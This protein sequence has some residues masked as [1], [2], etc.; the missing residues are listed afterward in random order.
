ML[1]GFLTALMGNTQ[2]MG[3]FIDKEERSAATIQAI[4]VVSNYIV[5]SQ[6]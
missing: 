2:L 3:Y 4:G 6:V 5:L 1:Q